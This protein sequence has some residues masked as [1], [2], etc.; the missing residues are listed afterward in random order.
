MLSQLDSAD[1]ELSV[2]LTN[3]AFI[4]SLNAKHR[5]KNVPTDVLAFPMEDAGQAIRT[6]VRL[7]GDV[8]ISI[9]TA[10]RQA[11]K[12]RRLLVEEVTHLLAHGVLHLLGYDHRDDREE[13]EMNAMTLRL[14][15]AATS[16]DRA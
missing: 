2:L 8:V 14:C 7:L 5:G 1:A 16:P 4:Q 12:R 11:Q 10:A 9:D 15:R 6:G 13:R 3:D